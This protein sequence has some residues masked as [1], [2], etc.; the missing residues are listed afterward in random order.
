MKAIIE[1]IKLNK[2]LR[3]EI[4]EWDVLHLGKESI[5]MGS[6]ESINKSDS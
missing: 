5:R 2:I 4:L 6:Q 1:N 3:Y